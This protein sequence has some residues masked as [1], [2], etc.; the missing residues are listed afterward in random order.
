MNAT[1][2]RG[3]SDVDTIA[4]VVTAPGEGGVAII[5][6]S[7]PRAFEISDKIF[8]CSAPPP[9]QRKG[10]TFVFGRVVD[11]SGSPIDEA[12]M[13]IMRAPH[14]YTREDTIEIQCHGGPVL[15]RKIL[16]RALEAGARAAEPGEF[17]KRAFLNGRIDL[18]QAEAVADL[19]RARSDRAAAAAMQQLQGKLSARINCLYDALIEAAANVEAT[20]DFSDQELPA[21]ILDPVRERLKSAIDEMRALLSTWTEGRLLRDGATV[22]IAG[23][24]N[25]GKSTLLNS[26]LGSDR[27]IVSH[28]PGTTRDTIEET[29]IIE[30]YP[31]K[32]VDTAGIR[33][34][35]CEVE[36][37]GIRRTR[38]VMMSADLC[39]YVFD[40]RCGFDS[41]DS[42]ALRSVPESKIILVANKL[43]LVGFNYNFDANNSIQKA[44]TSCVT[45]FGLEDLKRIIARKLGGGTAQGTHHA[46]ISTRHYSLIDSAMNDATY[47]LDRLC[48]GES[49]LDLVAAHLRSAAENLGLI[50]GRSFHEDLIGSIFSRFCIGK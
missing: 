18:A 46:A 19:I 11:A 12:I 50:T 31:V 5:R 32:L 42:E 37:E 10:G 7:G 33:A 14:S 21:G 40:A 48:N 27:A 22:V 34:T 35:S 39:L 1:S 9:S 6:V 3:I 20:L 49:D 44:Y 47:A 26:L 41:E 23:K 45:G 15:T 43:D 17:T 2:F 38:E 28:I 30:G 36:I 29:I 25:A 16:Q 13:L 8:S 4:A 24:P